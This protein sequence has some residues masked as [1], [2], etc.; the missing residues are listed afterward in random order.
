MDNVYSLS[1]D[2]QENCHA[3][4]SISQ[5][6]IAS[7]DPSIEHANSGMSEQDSVL[8]PSEDQMMKFWMQHL[9]ALVTN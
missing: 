5:V 6:S 1:K 2:T 7:L 9:I 8:K 3:V 4:N